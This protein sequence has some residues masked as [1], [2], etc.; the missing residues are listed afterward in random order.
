MSFCASGLSWDACHPYDQ[1]IA[2]MT[3]VVPDGPGL[4]WME[5]GSNEGVNALMINSASAAIDDGLYWHTSDGGK[6]CG[7]WDYSGVNE[8]TAGACDNFE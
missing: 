8:K 4:L 2:F 1:F 7:I 6:A 5:V 3:H